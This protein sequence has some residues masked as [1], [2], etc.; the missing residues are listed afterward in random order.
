MNF[1]TMNPICP[2]W[3]L[4]NEVKWLSTEKMRFFGFKWC[5]V[6]KG[7]T[8]LGRNS[9]LNSESLPPS[10]LNLNLQCSSLVQTL[11]MI[12]WCMSRCVSLCAPQQ[13]KINGCQ[14]I[15]PSSQTYFSIK[16]TWTLNQM[17]LYIQETTVLI[18]KASKHTSD[19]IKPLHKSM[20]SSHTWD[21]AQIPWIT[22]IV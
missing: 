11:M 18:K 8:Y 16:L 5:L 15:S 20:P 10:S 22:T 19:D 12:G 21:W 4:R 9:P 7:D 6:I 2:W 14:K 13:K 1:Q 3:K 17:H